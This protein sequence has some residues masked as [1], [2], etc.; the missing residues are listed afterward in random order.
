M[1]D[2]E[3]GAWHG[4]VWRIWDT[5]LDEQLAETLGAVGGDDR[6]CSGATVAAMVDDK[7][8]GAPGGYVPR[9]HVAGIGGVVL[10]RDPRS[11]VAGGRNVSGA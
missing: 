3:V 1:I 7:P 4:P 6:R 2:Y 10:V 9:G 11:I 8:A 5:S